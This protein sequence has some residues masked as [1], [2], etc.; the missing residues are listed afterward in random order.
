MQRSATFLPT[1]GDSHGEGNSNGDGDGDGNGDSVTGVHV[2]Q[3]C[4]NKATKMLQWCYNGVTVNGGSVLL[5]YMPPS[6]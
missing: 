3:W 5:Q 4:Y 1:H 2:I 6:Q